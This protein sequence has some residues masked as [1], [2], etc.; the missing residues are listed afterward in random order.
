MRGTELSSEVS[1]RYTGPFLVNISID[2][3]EPIISGSVSSFYT[4]T[5]IF[6]DVTQFGTNNWLNGYADGACSQHIGTRKKNGF[7][8]RRF[9]PRASEPNLANAYH[10]EK[11]LLK[12]SSF[13]QFVYDLELKERQVQQQSRDVNY[14]QLKPFL[15]TPESR[16]SA[17]KTYSLLYKTGTE[18]MSEGQTNPA[19]NFD[20]D[21]IE[22]TKQD[23]GEPEFQIT[24]FGGS[25]SN[26]EGNSDDI[27]TYTVSNDDENEVVQVTR[28]G[29]KENDREQSIK[30]RNTY[31]VS[32]ETEVKETVLDILH[33]SQKK[34]KVD[35]SHNNNEVRKDDVRI[36]ISEHDDFK[37]EKGLNVTPKQTFKQPGPSN[38]FPTKDSSQTHKGKDEKAVR[39]SLT[40][41]T[42]PP[43]DAN[44]RN[45]T[46]QRRSFF[47]A[48]GWT[49]ED[50]KWLSWIEVKFKDIAGADGEIDLEEFKKALGVKKSFFAERF[51]ELFD[52]DGSGAIELGE[53]MDGLRM[54]TKGTPVQ[55][56]QFLFDV[57]DADASGTIDRDE[58]MAVLRACMEES[59]LSLTEENLQELTDVLF[60]DADEDESGTITFE[61]LKTELEK[62]PGV[63]ENLTISAAQWL[64]TPDSSKGKKS[65]FRYFT[66]DYW[67][68]NYRKIGYFL[69]Y[70]ALNIVLY[71]VAMWQ[72]R[73][74]NTWVMFARGGGL[75]LNFN[76]MWVLVLMLRKSLTFLRMTKLVYIL[77]LDQAIQF[78]KMTA[79]AIVGFAII[80]TLAHIGNAAHAANASALEMWEV[81]FTVKAGVGYVGGSAFI[82]GWLL[83]IILIV[84]VIC[85]MPFIRRGGHFQVFY[86]THILYVPFW[87]LVILH[88]P[89]F[90]KWFIVPGVIFIL[91]KICRSK[92][93]KMA[94]FGDTYIEEVNLLPSGVTH[95]VITRPSNFRYKPGDYIFIQIPEIATHEWHPFTI[96]SAPEMEG[97]IWLHVRSAGHWT[98]KLY[99]HFDNLEAPENIEEAEDLEASYRRRASRKFENFEKAYSRR[100]TV[101]SKSSR[102]ASGRGQ[103]PKQKHK[104]VKVKCYIDGPYGT[105][106]REVFDTDHAVLV[107]AGI[108]VTPMA[109]ILQSVWY[110]FNAVRQKCPNCEHVWY[111]EEETFDMKLRKVDFIWINRDQKSFE[112]FLT[113]L[114]QIEV[115]Q[116]S[117]HGILENCI[118]MH[119]YMTAAQKKTDMKGIG[120]QIA[121]DLMYDKSR[122]DLITGLRTKTEPG[123]P[124]WNKIFNA[125]KAENK[126]KVKVFFCGPPALGKTVKAMSEKF[127]FAFSKEIF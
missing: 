91:E 74:S 41:E 47:G 78:H 113:L 121:L 62:H 18:R 32:N 49:D 26:G 53:L 107:G 27:H 103:K 40:V 30:N 22:D 64:K 83:D 106:T 102:R 54:L 117:H 12:A 5:T 61:E 75:C 116:S 34:D 48:Y 98:N 69:I 105:G 88:G 3:K 124:D 13:D 72:Y 90:W 37:D 2:G 96:S 73:D 89:H 122:R 38:G 65:S 36:T 59:S 39:Q 109:S 120:L 52:Q 95:L 92:F 56:L 99:E 50:T 42:A 84:M 67:K 21:G 46:P 112:W 33:K 58:L 60:D 111:P 29:G 101:L 68:N 6:H 119:M 79:W 19:F 43:L 76:C 71:A 115:E 85:S 44:N 126:G 80:H 55:K 108:G 28:F 57:Y 94:R 8:V 87:I 14:N 23:K 1:R 127:N 100:P 15:H 35:D 4:P 63:I 31:T 123:R 114:N 104:I 51:F 17:A 11:R 81:L 125:I 97:Y 70:W 110:R 7:H 82:T 16:E 77:P 25:V 118:Q 10:L 93:I 86:W 45:S 24:R 9:L 20:V 66:A